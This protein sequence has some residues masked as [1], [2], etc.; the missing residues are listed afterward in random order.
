MMRW[1]GLYHRE[2]SKLVST[3]IDMWYGYESTVR[4]I[5]SKIFL[6]RDIYDR[7]VVVAD[8]VKLKNYSV[9]LGGGV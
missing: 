1:T 9:V 7:E 8:K 4:N 2:R 6:R 5:R 3:L